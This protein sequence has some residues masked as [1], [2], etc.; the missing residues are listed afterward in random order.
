M[1]K[2]GEMAGLTGLSVKALRHYDATGT[3][4][5]A[6]VD[7][8]TAYRLYSEGQVRAGIMLRALRDAGLSL[9]TASTAISS[10]E[11]DQAME[12][13]RGR[14]LEQRKREDRTFH[15][16]TEILRALAV[17][18]TVS[19]RT[20]PTQC[21]VGQVIPV[22]VDDVDTVSDDDAAEVF[23][24]LFA[25]LKDAGVGPSGHF[26]TTLRADDQGNVELV[27]CWPTHSLVPEKV[28]GPESFS[29]ILPARKELV[30]T[31]HPV[32]DE[33]LPEGTLHPAAIG[34]FDE[35]AERGATLDN[36]ELR[37]S[38]IG[39]SADDYVVELSV[40]LSC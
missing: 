39:Q 40:T 37:Q 17:P 34:L 14:V 1:L 33:Q 27:C 31:W 16:A 35:I 20:M 3:L 32:N 8:R 38:V 11:V 29:D 7:E 30:A 4:V 26:W 9:P 23:G 24:E 12:I 28:L 2:I 13:H 22:P 15:E 19:E 5:P 36:V 25:R 18:T 21:F 10:G 6:A